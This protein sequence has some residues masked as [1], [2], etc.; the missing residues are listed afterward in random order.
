MQ[1]GPTCKHHL[2][3][4]RKACSSDFTSAYGILA[5]AFGDEGVLGFR[6]LRFGD[7]WL[8]EV[9]T[10]S[11]LSSTLSAFPRKPDSLARTT[12]NS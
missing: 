6:G 12:A 4:G 2:T 11:P 1:L 8:Y 3:I 10:L 9:S 7:L 5:Q